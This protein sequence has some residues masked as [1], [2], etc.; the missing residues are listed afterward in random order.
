MGRQLRPR[1]SRP[2]YATDLDIQ[3]EEAEE[4]TQSRPRSEPRVEGELEDVVMDYESSGSDFTLDKDQSKGKKSEKSGARSEEEPGDGSEEEEMEG[5]DSEEGVD[6]KRS[7]TVKGKGK[8]KADTKPAKK[9][10]A[11]GRKVR[12]IAHGDAMNPY[13]ISDNAGPS[14]RQSVFTKSGIRRHQKMY[15]LPSPSVHHRHRPVPLFNLPNTKVDRLLSPPKLFEEPRTEETNGFTSHPRICDRVGK[16][17]GYNVGPGPLWELVEDRSWFKEACMDE[18]KERRTRPRVHDHISVKGGWKILSREQ[19]APYLPADITTSDNGQLNPPPPVTCSF[20][21]F[22][23]QTK[24]EVDMF[25]A[26]SMAHYIPESRAHVFNPGAPAWGLDWCPIHEDDRR[27]RPTQYLAVAPYPSKQHSPEIGKKTEPGI[28]SHG[29][30]QIWS[31]APTKELSPGTCKTDKGKRKAVDNVDANS[32][33]IMNDNLEDGVDVGKMSCEMVLCLDSGPVH[34]LKWVPLP[35]NSALVGKDPNKLGKLG[36]L[37]GTFEDG[38]FAIYVVPHPVDVRREAGNTSSDEPIFVS[39]PAPIIKVELEAE[40]SYW[41]FDW[42]NSEVVAIGTTGGVIVVHDLASAFQAVEKP[43]TPTLTPSTHPHVML[44]THYITVHQCAIRALAWL[45]APPQW[46][47][48]QAADKKKGK[49]CEY[50]PGEDWDC[51]TVIASGGYDGMECITDI[52]GGRGVVMNR[53]RDV[54]N[55]MTFSQFS[56]GPITIDHENIVKAYSASPMML[57]RGH[58]LMEPQGPV[59]SIDA[60][61]YHPQLVVGSADGSCTTTNTLRSTRRDGPVPFLIHKIYQMDYN[62]NLKEFRML[63]KFLSL[64]TQEKPTFGIQKAQ[65]KAQSKLKAK[66]APPQP[67]WN[68]GAWPQEVGIQVVTWNS[69]NGLSNAGLL[70]SATGSGLCRVDYLWGRWMRNKRPYTDITTVRMEDM[71]FGSSSSDSE[72]T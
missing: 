12:I 13:A 2:S 34:S 41:S 26:F 67:D 28:L 51:P 16:S 39:L 45:R 63:D 36:L 40:T 44:P 21:P 30:V 59:W 72:S 11:Q 70:A 31:L 68:T 46:Y 57:G 37:S 14:P 7:H 33:Q 15:S 23:S 17:W 60:S 24:V 8:A 6:I 29:S 65:T 71:E 9:K 50:P 53:T 4:A 5:D 27:V 66:S 47:L 38:S 18:T 69:S 3:S 56:G 42:A 64:E 10:S 32:D 55:T 43:D 19:A 20:G 52:R 35:T 61:D 49:N 48:V 25:D 62:R 1:K 22:D 58:L 54:I